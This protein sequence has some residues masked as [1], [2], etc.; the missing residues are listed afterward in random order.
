MTVMCVHCTVSKDP[1]VLVHLCTVWVHYSQEVTVLIASGHLCVQLPAMM[2]HVHSFYS[3]RQLA[4]FVHVFKFTH[5][6]THTHT[7]TASEELKEIIA[8][9]L[10]GSLRFLKINI[11]DGE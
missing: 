10:N 5:T 7:Q 11:Q 9:A 3:E 2:W 4:Y 6:L 1:C 8:K